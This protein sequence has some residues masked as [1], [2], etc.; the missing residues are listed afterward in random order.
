MVFSFYASDNV[1]PTYVTD[2]SCKPVGEL[3]VDITGAGTD[4]SVSVQL[5]FSGTE[6]EAEAVEKQT[7]M[8]TNAKLDFLG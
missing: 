6:L 4:W 1:K 2:K 5:S 3:T 7:G 8:K